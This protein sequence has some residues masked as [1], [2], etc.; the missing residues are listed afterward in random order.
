MGEVKVEE[1]KVGV[2]PVSSLFDELSGGQEVTSEALLKSLM[3]SDSN[4]SM[5]SFVDEPVVLTVVDVLT[6]YALGKGY[7]R[8]ARRLS[9]LGRSYR[10]NQCSKDGRRSK[11]V[12][13]GVVANIERSRQENEGVKERLVGK[14]GSR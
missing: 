12:V 2:L 6:D 7:E 13:E 3:T 10:E 5:I 8:V 11:Q 4:L 14:G 9:V 1:K